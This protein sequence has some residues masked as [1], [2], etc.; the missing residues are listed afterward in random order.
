M[1]PCPHMPAAPASAPITLID[2]LTH[3]A[4]RAG[5]TNALRCR[6]TLEEAQEK[7]QPLI[8]AI[9]D[10]SLV[11]EEQ[12]FAQLAQLV[13]LP[14]VPDGVIEPP[15]GGLHS[16]LPAKLA[17]RHR[18]YPH[19]VNGM[20]VTLLTYDPFDLDARQAVGQ[21]LRKRVHWQI[22]SRPRKQ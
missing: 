17:L 19:V 9:L 21:E 18:L 20:D 22:A 3:A 5:C 10:G 1:P 7:R 2:V 14:F 12:F 6:E 4:T 13:Q 16:K 11:E 8:D 15:E